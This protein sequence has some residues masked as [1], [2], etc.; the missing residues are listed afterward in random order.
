MEPTRRSLDRAVEKSMDLFSRAKV[1][2]VAAVEACHPKSVL[3][4]LDGSSQDAFGIA[5]ARQF[6][7]RFGCR[8][9]VVDAREGETQDDLAEEVAKSLD[10]QAEATEPDDSFTQILSAVESSNCDLLITPCPYGRDL[11]TVGPD[12]TGTVI[13]VLLARSPVP[14]LVVRRP[15][16]P[17]GDLFHQIVMT[18]TAE[19]EAAP[20]AAAWAAGL[21]APQG[22][23]HL[24]LELERE[25][26]QNVAALMQAI[27]PE[28][29]I[30]I[31]SLSHALARNY[32]R[33]HRGLQKTAVEGGFSYKLK[34][35]VEG[36]AE[37]IA[38]EDASRPTL[39]VLALERHDHVSQGN[40]Q[41]RIR[42]SL[43]PVLVVCRPKCE[44]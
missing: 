10:G 20:D 35:E 21:I 26:H 23:F 36:E 34:L 33:L 12:S 42:Q 18:L 1:G 41:S 9:A 43:H 40:V 15:F 31:D 16:E 4:A 19:N 38:K 3:L 11:E 25:M 27:A 29:D 32:M 2:T 7:E 6:R 14:I 13:D 44:E 22:K 37:P 28:V 30:S 17:Q 8:L 39:R 24:V 5:I